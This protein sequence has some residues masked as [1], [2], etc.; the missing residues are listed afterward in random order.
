MAINRSTYT[1]R[2]RAPALGA[3][4]L[5]P[6]RAWK[7]RPSSTAVHGLANSSTSAARCAMETPVNNGC[8]NTDRS[9]MP[10]TT[11][12]CPPALTHQLVSTRTQEKVMGYSTQKPS[13]STR[14]TSWS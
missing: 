7:P 8:V 14:S 3:R 13:P 10:L 12:A 9:T 4:F 2:Y 6:P 11:S 1:N 5:I